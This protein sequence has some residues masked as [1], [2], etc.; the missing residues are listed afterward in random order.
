MKIKTRSLVFL[1]SLFLVFGANKVNARPQSKIAKEKTATPLIAHPIMAPSY[2]LMDVATGRVLAARNMHERR[3]PASTTK[4]MTALLAIEKGDLDEVVTIGP[5]PPKVGESSIYLQAGERMPLYGL[6]EAAMIRSANDSCVA[7]AEAVGGSEKKFVDMMNARARQLG[8]KDTHFM[9]PHGLHDPNHYTTA[10]DL[11]LIAREAMTHP[12]FND[13]I[14]TKETLITGPAKQGGVRKIFN[15]NK[16]LFRWD[17]ADGVKTGTTRQAGGCLIA[18][19]T[20]VDPVTKR[21]WRLLAVVL[22]SKG[23]WSDAANLLIK[24]G[25]EKYQPTVVAHA[26]EV[27]ADVKVEGGAKLV[28]AVA[29]REIRLPLLPAEKQLLTSHV[30]PLERVAPIGKG[31]TVAW[32]AWDLNDHKIASVPL[33]ASEP[34]GVSLAAK[35]FPAAAPIVPSQPLLRWSVYALATT[36]VLLLLAGWKVKNNDN[37]RKTR[38]RKQRHEKNRRSTPRESHQQIE[39]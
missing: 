30:Q 8:A 2:V 9:N 16:L 36:G 3:F 5:N 35:I 39:N 24:Q 17:E 12:I 26:G 32:L 23:K 25:F 7:I 14:R 37:Q 27:L 21:P 15:R 13:I 34:I 31:Q 22:H 28:P 20:R 4:T 33:V 18:S 29:A 38:Q 10:Y 6:V 19:A 1:L 11:A